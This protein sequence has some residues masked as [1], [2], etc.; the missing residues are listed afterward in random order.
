MRV[1]S[2]L[3][4]FAISVEVCHSQTNGPIWPGRQ[5]DGS[6]LLPN[7]W[8]LRPAGSRQIELGDFPV[9]VALTPDGRYAAV[10][11]CG[12]SHHEVEV[13]DLADGT[14]TCR[15][16]VQEAF[17]G[18]TFSAD[19]Q[20]LY[21]SGASGEDI[22]TFHF[23]EGQLERTGNLRLHKP[24]DTGVP[25][26]LA[27]DNAGEK[28]YAANLWSSRISCVDLKTKSVCDA[29][30]DTNAETI[31]LT[32]QEGD[33]LD[34]RAA[35]KRAWAAE[36]ARFSNTSGAFPYA[37]VLDPKR[38]RLYVSL[39]GAA[40]VAVLDT[41]TNLMIA[42]WETGQHP[43]E[44]VLSRDGKRL[45]VANANENTVS[46]ID[47]ITGRTIETLWATL[48]PDSP[49][50]TTPNSLALSPDEKTLFVANANINAI[51]VF[52]VSDPGRIRYGPVAGTRSLQ[53]Q[54][55]QQRLN[56]DSEK[57]PRS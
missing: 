22:H 17:Y 12:Y 26:G 49:R 20:R 57:R 51:A 54:N 39:W 55:R 44:M 6:M 50:G 19:G 40:A 36:L 42:R 33:D 30:L 7:Q 28:L 18:V 43:C 24:R 29:V 47:T 2:I 52:D 3:L 46:E 48:F 5:P 34:T 16:N 1:L 11:H 31:P 45:F 14:V 35:T 13:V 10:L 25:C 15:T 27:I 23:H 32:P 53:T 21:C 38:H 41:R 4:I 37:C 9:N 56:R 8:S